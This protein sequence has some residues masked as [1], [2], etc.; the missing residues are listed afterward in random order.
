MALHRPA[1]RFGAPQISVKKI[2]VRLFGTVSESIV[3]G[4]G[5]RFV[6]FVQ[7][8]PHHCPGCHNPGSHDPEGGTLTDTSALWDTILKYPHI[9]GITFSGGEPFTH[10]AALAELGK[11]AREKG[12][13]VMT[14][15]GYTY[16]R[17]LEMAETDSAVHE[18]LTVTNYLVDGPFILAE[19]DLTLKYRG[20]RNQRILDVTCYPNSAD[21]AE[22]D[23]A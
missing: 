10:A 22:A 18:L 19:R 9:D 20:S 6:I 5:I 21:A 14:Y 3:D 8:C 12:L 4:P 11:A 15:S 23:F 13:N 2:P 7:G 1:R 17:L 16:G